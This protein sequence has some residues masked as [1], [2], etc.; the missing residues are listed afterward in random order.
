MKQQ[1]NEFSSTFFYMG[2][3]IDITVYNVEDDTILSEV[4]DLILKYDNMFSRHINS[5]EISQ[6]NESG[7]LE[8]SDDTKLLIE[9]SLMYSQIS[10]GYFDITINP[11]VEL[12]SIGDVGAK[13]PTEKEIILALEKVG[14]EN[15]Y[16]D[17]QTILLNG[18]TIDLGGIAKGFIADKIVALLEENNVDK[19]LINLGGNVYALGS[20]QLDEDWNIGIRTPSFDEP[21]VLLKL[22]L[23]NKSV[24]TSGV[25]E[26]YLEKDG[27]IYHHIFNPFNGYPMNNELLSLTV[28]SNQSI[29]G[30]ALSTALF[31]LGLNEAFSL[32]NKLGVEI[33][34]VTR[35]NDVYISQ[36]LESK[37]YIRKRM[38]ITIILFRIYFLVQ[39]LQH[40]N[41]S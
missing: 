29:D 35:E 40:H 34:A 37:M 12:W 5:S 9:K 11:I 14:Y 21:G 4:S 22:M 10:D 33:I 30:D 18:T 23:K 20:S 3:V 32:S 2:T 15:I 1:K 27:Q 24:V 28:I 41:S 13:V 39:T 36:S 16:I 7:Q 19:A 6:L 25:Y 38:I 31:N 17:G 26:R 8:V